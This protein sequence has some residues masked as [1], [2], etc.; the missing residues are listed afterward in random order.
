[1]LYFNYLFIKLLILYLYTTVNYC[2]EFTD[3][4]RNLIRPQGHEKRRGSRKEEVWDRETMFSQLAKRS[5]RVVVSGKLQYFSHSKY[6]QTQRTGRGNQKCLLKKI[7]IEKNN[8]MH[9]FF[10]CISYLSF[11]TEISGET[12][13]DLNQQQCSRSIGYIVFAG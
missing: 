5:P 6:F 12:V 13:L 10:F 2:V 3:F 1:M 4:I 8:I 11:G 9:F 7:T